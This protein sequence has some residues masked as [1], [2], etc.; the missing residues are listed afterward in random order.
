MPLPF[1]RR[2]AAPPLTSVDLTEMRD[3]IESVRVDLA[4]H[5]VLTEAQGK[6]IAELPAEILLHFEREAAV[7][8][9]KLALA[10]L[11]KAKEEVVSE[12][13][14]WGTRAAL[15][16]LCTYLVAQWGTLLGV[17]HK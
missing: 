5:R 7:I 4:A 3:S 10:A 13:I 14:K 11:K 2:A 8:A 6:A 1:L 15:G 16:A 17:L 9:N 12:T